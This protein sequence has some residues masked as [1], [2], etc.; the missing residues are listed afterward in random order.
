MKRRGQASHRFASYLMG[1][2]PVAPGWVDAAGCPLTNHKEVVI[3]R[4]HVTV[5]SFDSIHGKAEVE[6]LQQTV[7]QKNSRDPTVRQ[8]D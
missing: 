4:F 2:F 6:A 3:M 8:T 7:G 1:T 5:M